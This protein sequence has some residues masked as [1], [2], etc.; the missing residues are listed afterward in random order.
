MYIKNQKNETNVPSKFYLRFTLFFQRMLPIF[1]DTETPITDRNTEN[2]SVSI[3]D[4][5][6]EKDIIPKA[7]D[8]EEFELEQTKTIN[9]GST[10]K[11]SR[12]LTNIV[13]VDN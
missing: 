13:R 10:K 12:E 8:D 1:Y 11:V 6:K 9:N 7:L 2:D 3:M 4:G 5:S